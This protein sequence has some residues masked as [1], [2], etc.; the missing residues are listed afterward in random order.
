[1]VPQGPAATHNSSIPHLFLPLAATLEAEGKYGK[2][3]IWLPLLHIVGGIYA[4]KVPAVQSE[5]NGVGND[6]RNALGICHSRE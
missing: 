1:M 2:G 4:S 6:A 3:A 5:V